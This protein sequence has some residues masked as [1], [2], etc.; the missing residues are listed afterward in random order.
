MAIYNAYP[1]SEK[2]L[3]FIKDNFF[4]MTNP[5]LAKALGL[6]LTSVRTKCLELGLKRIE[7]QY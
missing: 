1:W 5:N 7:M 4:K 2:E 3:Q 6:K